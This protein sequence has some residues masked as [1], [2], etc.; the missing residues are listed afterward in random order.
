[1]QSWHN[2]WVASFEE[3]KHLPSVPIRI[4]LPPLTSHYLLMP[5]IACDFYD[6]AGFSARPL[7]WPSI[8]TPRREHLQT[9]QSKKNILVPWGQ[10]LLLCFSEHFIFIQHI[11]AAAHLGH[12][13]LEKEILNLKSF[14]LP[15]WI[16]VNNK[17]NMWILGCQNCCLIC[18]ENL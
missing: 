15:G 16:K 14:F 2:H 5:L 12:G 11:I 10:Q 4:S 9:T 18:S 17:N 8:D 6:V 13:S 7:L 3:I 1:M